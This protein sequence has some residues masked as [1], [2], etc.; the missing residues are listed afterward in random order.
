MQNMNEIA[1]NE[2][3][4]LRELSLD[5][6]ELVGGGFS[7]GGLVH[8]VEHVAAKA[9][10][11]V[12]NGVGGA[13]GGAIGGAIVAAKWLKKEAPKPPKEDPTG[14]EDPFNFGDPVDFPWFG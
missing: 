2:G 5:E 14:P 8:G 7:W 11:A 1:P 10:D 13:V 4:T 3:T 6:T 12:I 9:G